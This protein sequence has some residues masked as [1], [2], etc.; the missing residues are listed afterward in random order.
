MLGSNVCVVKA[1]SKGFNI[2]RYPANRVFYTERQLETWL[3]NELK[4]VA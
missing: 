3:D 1:V 4:K 2:A